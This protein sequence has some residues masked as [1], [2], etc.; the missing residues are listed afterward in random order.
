MVKAWIADAAPLYERE[1]YERYYR[2]LPDFRKSKADKLRLIERKAQSVGVW[3]LWQK[4]RE[5]YSLSGE[6]VFNLS[7]SGS[8]VMCAANMGGARVKVGCDVEKI[9]P[10][11]LNIAE[12]Y[13]CREE[14]RTMTDEPSEEKRAELFYR[15]WVLKESFMKATR[16]GM[17]LPAS[18]FCIQLGSPPVLIRQ[19]DEFPEKYYYCEYEMNDMPYKMAV[20]TTDEEIDMELH[21]ELI[22]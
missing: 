8:L 12:K 4:I 9:G 11:H 6:T 20:C 10:M 15:Y 16:K 17:A 5:R 1:C 2:Q 13:F 14:Y 21:T 7:H 18:R 3:I 19:P 22:L